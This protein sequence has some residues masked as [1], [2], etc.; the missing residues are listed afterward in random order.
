MRKIIALI[1]ALSMLTCLFAGCKNN[2]NGGQDTPGDASGS[3]FAGNSDQTY[4]MITFYPSLS[5]WAPCWQGFQDAA[6]ALGVKAEL[7]GP[8]SLVAA[9]EI[10]VLEQAATMG[11][12]AICVSPIEPVS[13]IDAINTT[14]AEGTPVMCF[15][16]DSPESDRLCYI[17]TSNYSAGQAGAEQLAKEIG[18]SGDVLLFTMVGQLN[19]QERLRG[20]QEYL[21]ENYP[22]IT[23]VQVLSAEATSDAAAAAVAAALQANPNVK[24]I[25]STVATG[26]T[27]AA[28]TIKELDYQMANIGFDTDVSVLSC[29]Q[30]GTAS[31]T[32]SQN[33]YVMGYTMLMEMYIYC[34]N[35][36]NPYENWKE[37]GIPAIPSNIDTGITIVTRDNLELFYTPDA[38]G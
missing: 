17:G 9:E 36:S 31:A 8:S 10:A 14:I 38:E 7:A 34:N 15:D 33:Y 22:D 37:N 6:A 5:L 1:L 12:T 26:T 18:G 2:E 30:E 27:G 20:A 35:L 13:F 21:A 3:P 32:V 11:A 29:I 28:Q 4:Y 25:F 23:V 24:G 16:S 19:H